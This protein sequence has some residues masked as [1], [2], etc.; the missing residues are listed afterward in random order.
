M[1]YSLCLSLEY[2]EDDDLSDEDDEDSDDMMGGMMNDLG[3][4]GLI[5]E[6]MAERGKGKDEKGN[7]TGGE[8]L[9]VIIERG[10][11]MSGYVSKNHQLWTG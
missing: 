11:C 9:G 5:D 3:I 10:A 8:V 2:E 1:L 6:K 7:I 4:P